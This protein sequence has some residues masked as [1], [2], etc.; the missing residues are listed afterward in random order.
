MV[1]LNNITWKDLI[2]KAKNLRDIY[3]FHFP[4]YFYK[5]HREGL[6]YLVRGKFNQYNSNQEAWENKI[7]QM[8]L[9]LHQIIMSLKERVR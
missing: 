2:K 6:Y 8:N 9:Y 1:K 7:M 5:L 4:I 3:K